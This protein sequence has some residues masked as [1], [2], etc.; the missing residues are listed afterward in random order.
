MGRLLN[1]LVAALENALTPNCFFLTSD[2]GEAKTGLV[3]EDL[4]NGRGEGG[5]GLCHSCRCTKET[6]F[7]SQYAFRQVDSVAHG[8]W[9][10][11]DLNTFSD[12]SCSS[13]LD[14]L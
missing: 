4:R 11:C 6:E 14:S 13:V 8:E 12:N 1:F 2:T 10:C 3:V 7:C 5:R 9:Q